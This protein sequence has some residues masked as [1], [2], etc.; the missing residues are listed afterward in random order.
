MKKVVRIL[1]LAALPLY[2][3]AIAGAPLPIKGTVCYSKS[4]RPAENHRIACADL[5]EFPS[6][7]AIYAAGFRVV[8]SGVIQEA[9]GSTIFLIIEERK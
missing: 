6:V 8:S 1:A 5:G 2:T 3:P 7:E 4:L 9:G